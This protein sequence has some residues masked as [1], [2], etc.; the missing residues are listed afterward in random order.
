[1]PTPS[2]RACTGAA[3]AL[4]LL[5]LPLTGCIASQGPGQTLSVSDGR[6]DLVVYLV[7]DEGALVRGDAWWAAQ[8][9]ELDVQ[10]QRVV[11]GWE[12]LVLK[13]DVLVDREPVLGSE[14]R[15]FVV[16]RSAPVGTVAAAGD[17][18]EFLVVHTA[19]EET[20]AQ[21]GVEIEA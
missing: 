4:V 21:F 20:L 14:E 12:V 13:N 3:L 11:P 2:S 16:W 15:A 10:V 6:G 18:F 9:P 7:L 5:L 17:S 19:D 8:A 1:M